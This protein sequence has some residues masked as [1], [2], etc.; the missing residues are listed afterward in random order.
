MLIHKTLS[1]LYNSDQRLVVNLFDEQ[2]MV[3]YSM[4]LHLAPYSTKLLHLFNLSHK[5][6]KWPNNN[7]VDEQTM[8]EYLMTL[9]L[10][11]YSIKLLYLFNLA[12]VPKKATQ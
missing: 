3:E 7:L 2:T 4:T 12:H 9:I 5:F 11:P 6:A 8:A 10:A 1:V